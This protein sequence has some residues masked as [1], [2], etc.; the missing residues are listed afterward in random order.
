MLVQS[1]VLIWF[2]QSLFKR[3][4]ISKKK[5]LWFLVVFQMVISILA[6]SLGDQAMMIIYYSCLN[7]VGVI[8]IG[9]WWGK[10]E[11]EIKTEY[12]VVAV[13]FGWLIRIIGGRY[14]LISEA[15]IGWGWWVVWS[16]VS[17]KIRIDKIAEYGRRFSYL[18]YLW[19][20]PILYLAVS[21]VM[22]V[23]KNF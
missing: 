2:G 17:G 22:F 1:Y 9:Y 14:W 7:Y 12:G 23:V 8:G 11:K 10:Y 19:H 16:E 5:S 4:N 20:L 21:L 6:I 3:L 18:V 13:C 15:L